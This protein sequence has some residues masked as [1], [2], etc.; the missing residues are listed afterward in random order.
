M[1]KN[2]TLRE[3]IAEKLANNIFV[4][5]IWMFVVFI[6]STLTIIEGISLAKKTA[7][8]TIFLRNTHYQM[9]EEVRVNKDISSF[10]SILGQPVLKE[11]NETYVKYTFENIDF[12]LTALTDNQDRVVSLAVTSKTKN[13]KP[14]F[15]LPGYK[16]NGYL[17]K[18]TLNETNFSDIHPT[19]E[20]PLIDYI[21]DESLEEM[22]QLN[23]MYQTNPSC[24]LQ[25]GV[26]RFRY[27]EGSYLGNPSNY[28][29]IYYGIN[30]AGYMEDYPMPENDDLWYILGT[31]ECQLIDD[32]FRNS[33]VNTFAI[34]A[35]H[36]FWESSVSTE[37]AD[38]IFGPDLDQV[39]VFS[40]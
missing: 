27:F 16:V 14:S 10:I 36:E 9:L 38:L 13:F 34:T 11:K 31:E 12:Y 23:F 25:I 17:G 21:E 7:N 19:I 22:K 8:N 33:K 28:Q 24:F 20:K 26:R 2:K 5:L 37:S 3:K 29:T 35:P 18:I 39:R 15:E 40:N 6:S 30:D 4:V 32:N 1:A